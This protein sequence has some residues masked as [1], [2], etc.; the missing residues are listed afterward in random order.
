LPVSRP[1][2]GAERGR[3]VAEGTPSFCIRRGKSRTCRPGKRRPGRETRAAGCGL[4]RKA[5]TDVSGLAKIGANLGAAVEAGACDPVPGLILRV[6]ETRQRG[7][8]P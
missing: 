8:V 5:A 7:S 2:D 3:V 6:I 4:R 1:E